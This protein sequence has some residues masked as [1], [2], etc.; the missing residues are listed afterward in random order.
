MTG[1]IIPHSRPK[2]AILLV[3]EGVEVALI[4]GYDVRMAGVSGCASEG[5]LRAHV[6][7]QE[8]VPELVT[9]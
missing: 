2:V 6:P 5:A 8:A 3:E 4:V 7:T 1:D 9:V